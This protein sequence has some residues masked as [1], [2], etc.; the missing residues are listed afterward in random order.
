M[1]SSSK[2]M[3]SIPRT[4]LKSRGDRSFSVAGPRLWNSL[5]LNIRSAQMLEHLKSLLKKHFYG[6]AFSTHLAPKH[7]FVFTALV[8]V[9]LICFYCLIPSLLYFIASLLC[10]LL[11]FVAFYFVKRSLQCATSINLTLTI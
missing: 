10:I 7:F 9:F 2:L 3:L 5:P 8:V 4:Y 11:I 1:R 6:L